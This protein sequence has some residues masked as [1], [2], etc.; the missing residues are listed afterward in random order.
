VKQGDRLSNL[1]DQDSYSY[2]VAV[3]F[4]GG[5]TSEDLEAKYDHILNQL[6]LKLEPVDT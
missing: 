5:E 3:I 1:K 2:E 6:P 4:I